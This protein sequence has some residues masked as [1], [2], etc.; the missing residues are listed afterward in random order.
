MI[1]DIQLPKPQSLSL[2]REAKKLYPSL[3]V[4]TMT[5]YSTSF[6]EADALRAGADAYF[7]KPFDLNSFVRKLKMMTNGAQAGAAQNELMA[8]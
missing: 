5:A 7:I 6:T 2:L 4:I 1:L 3:P 8:A